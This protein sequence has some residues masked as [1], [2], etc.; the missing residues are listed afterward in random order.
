MSEMLKTVRNFIDC[1]KAN[2]ATREQFKTNKLTPRKEYNNKIN[3]SEINTCKL[4]QVQQLINKDKDIVF[5]ALVAAD[6]IDKV[7]CT[8]GPS[9]QQAWLAGKYNLDDYFTAVAERLDIYNIDELCP[10]TGTVFQT[11]ANNNLDTKI[12]TLF[13][14]GAMKSVMSW[15]MYKKLKLNNLDTTRI[16]HVVEASGES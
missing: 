8:N 5:N 16:L 6:Y 11:F 15:N 13:D 12:N 2:P 3:E 4:D 10:T 9:H 14:T 7:N 1:M